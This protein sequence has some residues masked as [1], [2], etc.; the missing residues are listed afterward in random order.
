MSAERVRGVL[1]TAVAT[2]AVALPPA[3]ASLE[4]PGS[5]LA[6]SRVTADHLQADALAWRR[7]LGSGSLNSAVRR[8][9]SIA[10]FSPGPASRAQPKVRL[11]RIEA[12]L[13]PQLAA[14]VADLLTAVLSSAETM[15][16]AVR[17]DDGRSPSLSRRAERAAHDLIRAGITDAPAALARRIE[18]L[19]PVV[20]SNGV[21]AA[22]VRGALDVT[23]ALD[24]DLPLLRRSA[25]SDALFSSPSADDDCDVA[26]ELPLLCIG[27]TGANLHEND[28]A[29]V[30]D[31]GGDDRYQNS[32]GGANI[33]R[34]GASPD[35]TQDPSCVTEVNIDLG[36][37]DV[38]EPSLEGRVPYD[39]FIVGGSA[40][41]GVGVLVDTSGD[42]VYRVD[43]PHL[44]R[45]LD[46]PYVFGSGDLGVG[47]LADFGGDDSYGFSAAPDDIFQVAAIGSSLTG[48][49]AVLDFGG[50]NT[51]RAAVNGV[52]T[53]TPNPEDSIVANEFVNAEATSFFGSAALY[54][55]TGRA[56][57][58]STIDATAGPQAG[59]NLVEAIQALNIVGGGALLTGDAPTKYILT[60]HR[61]A[62]LD[63]ASPV[64]EGTKL[65]GE[66]VVSGQGVSA[67]ASEFILDD[68]GGNDLYLDTARSEHLLTVS[69]EAG[70]GCTGAVANLD[71][72][73]QDL[74]T[75]PA[76]ASA[77]GQGIAAALFAPDAA[78][79]VADHGG[80]DTYVIRADLVADATATSRA[81][82]GSSSHADTVPSVWPA[83]VSVAGQGLGSL[84][85]AILVNSGG[86]DS[87]TLVADG[88]S[89]ATATDESGQATSRAL[90]PT[91][92]AY[93]QGMDRSLPAAASMLL[94]EGGLDHYDVRAVSHAASSP[95]REL[96]YDYLPTNFSQGSA[97]GV[98]ADLDDDLNDLFVRTPEFGPGVGQRGEGPG[99]VDVSLDYPGFGV[100]PLQP[101]KG[102]TALTMDASNPSSAPG[103]IVPFTARLTDPGGLPLA[104]R[105]VVFTIEYQGSVLGVQE[106][107]HPFEITSAGLTD[108]NG[109]ATG[110]VD[111]DVWDAAE[112]DFGRAATLRV[113]AHYWGDDA[114]R[115]ALATTPFQLT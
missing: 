91:S 44:P 112:G 71:T 21:I 51:Y 4:T 115:P 2:L 56:T 85:P 8:L 83:T 89:H 102:T 25:G 62:R 98:F 18:R 73:V 36:G 30:I 58:A 55:R 11:G 49:G 29:L 59:F 37:N 104:G 81:P 77:G 50:S 84:A 75:E 99:W 108:E 34:C 6:S 12:H 61:V 5:A 19:R 23:A 87:Y 60:A 80:D 40:Y 28:A 57:I 63:S 13:A 48:I 97:G 3:H 78:A 52:Q 35:P 109:V 54:D 65:P 26:A 94:D 46:T 106:R 101:A 113:A 14:P 88:E 82:S 1:L 15:A 45:P 67:A 43:V 72:T 9:A 69:A 95:T 86:D 105:E 111:F 16:S 53:P 92:E 68:L 17:L 47:V 20:R 22:A 100:A 41:E 7:D 33:V 66:A 70:C 74:A 93:G 24:R 31:L 79:L 38:Y 39:H 110:Y 96:A 90:A 76:A 32:A 103:G 114:T 27:G 64:P 10:S 107:W 42:D